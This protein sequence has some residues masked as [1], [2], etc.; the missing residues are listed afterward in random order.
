MYQ[1]HD[2]P[3]GQSDDKYFSSISRRAVC[4]FIS[5]YNL[6]SIV[7]FGCGLGRTS[8]FIKENTGIE[9]LGVDISQTSIEKSRAN[10]PDI[11]FEVGDVSNI[12][13]YI[14]FECIFMS[15]ITWY[16]LENQVIDKLF[17]EMGKHMKGKYLIHNLVFYKNE[18]QNYGK[19]YFTNLD[20]FI[21]FCPFDLLGKTEVDMQNS[22]TVETSAIF[23]I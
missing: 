21:S 13:K 4:Y 15:E 3:W 14:D 22:N 1:S 11:D 8:N 9:I 2:D 10:F 12:N 16:L 6:K 19:D 5:Y 7:E 17:D 18:T 20:E 23:R